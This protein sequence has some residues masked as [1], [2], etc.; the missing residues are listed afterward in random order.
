MSEAKINRRRTTQL[1]C[2][3]ALDPLINLTHQLSIGGGQWPLLPLSTRLAS[4]SRL[5]QRCMFYGRLLL[6]RPALQVIVV[7]VVDMRVRRR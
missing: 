7:V 3:G 4:F 6:T 1:W 5:V 2:S